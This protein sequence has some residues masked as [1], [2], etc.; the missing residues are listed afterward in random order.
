MGAASRL[1]TAGVL[2]LV[3]LLFGCDRNGASPVSAPGEAAR[4]EHSPA[5]GQKAG[6]A[7][8]GLSVTL[9]PAEPTATDELVAVCRGC[10]GQ[11]SFRW[12]RNGAPI[13]GRTG[14]RLP[15][16]TFSRGDRITVDLT[17]GGRETRA[18]VTIG[19]SPPRVLS[20]TFEN[21]NFHRGVDITVIPQT[22]DPDGDP[23]TF[24][25]R[26][27]VN[28]EEAFADSARL[29]WDS[30]HRGDRIRL[31]IIPSDDQSDGPVFRSKAFVVPNAPPEFLSQPPKDFKGKLYVYDPEVKDPDGDTLSFSLESAPLD[32]SID[33]ARGSIRWPVGA[34][35]VGEHD[36]KILAQDG[37]GG[38]ASQEFKLTIVIQEQ[39]KN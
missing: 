20:A 25:Y 8:E 31:E 6:R 39:E 2:L 38:E 32:M 3:V 21:P 37:Q 18:A 12:E 15:V 22:D 33:P 11:V 14:S 13:S 19:N 28:G 36:I 1:I 10:S 24:R 35:D 27:L 9:L 5:P 34:G 4:S 23:M 17:S 26:W 29:P 16:G 30:F 7:A